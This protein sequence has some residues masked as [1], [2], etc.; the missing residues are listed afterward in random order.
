M[1]DDE[2]DFEQ[3]QEE[4]LGDADDDEIVS[5][6]DIDSD[7]DADTDDEADAEETVAVPRARK[8]EQVEV[9]SAE[10]RAALRNTLAADVEAFLA[11]GGSIVKVADDRHADDPPN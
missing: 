1:S 3:D 7:T 4:E 10:A 9:H 2:E 11:R 6:A 8:T 5:D